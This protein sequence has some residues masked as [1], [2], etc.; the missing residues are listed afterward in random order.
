MEDIQITE[1]LTLQDYQDM[2][3]NHPNPEDMIVG[4]K[5]LQALI[6]K[7]LELSK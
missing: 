1:E 4:S 7:I 6:N 5:S 3:D 2:C